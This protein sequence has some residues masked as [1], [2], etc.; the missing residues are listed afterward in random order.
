MEWKRK[1]KGVE[2]EGEKEKEGEEGYEERKKQ[3]TG[4][5]GRHERGSEKEVDIAVGL[6]KGLAYIVDKDSQSI[7]AVDL[8]TGEV[9]LLAGMGSSSAGAAQEAGKAQV[10]TK[11]WNAGQDAMHRDMETER[12]QEVPGGDR[13]IGAKERKEKTVQCG[14]CGKEEA[15]KASDVK[16]CERCRGKVKMC[17]DC[18]QPGQ[19]ECVPGKWCPTCATPWEEQPME[20]KMGCPKCPHN[21]VQY[22]SQM[23][24]VGDWVFH[25]CACR[26]HQ[27]RAPGEKEAGEEVEVPDAA[28]PEVA[29]EGRLAKPNARARKAGLWA[30]VQVTNM[31]AGGPRMMWQERGGKAGKEDLKELRSRLEGEG[32]QRDQECQD[33]VDSEDM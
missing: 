31:A 33:E 30:S 29:N 12:E 21:K 1:R 18:R 20:T 23:C 24:W 10:K 14:K 11:R 28:A 25:K 17:A 22:C 13:P 16:K 26:G 7:S 3:Q 19:H 9:S 2:V 6:K 8:R 15:E 27:K 32:G 4:K 5:K